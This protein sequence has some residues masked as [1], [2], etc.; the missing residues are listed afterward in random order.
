[1]SVGSRAL[2]VEP[3]DPTDVVSVAQCIAL[4]AEVFP[5]PS[6]QFGMRSAF[7]RVWVARERGERRVLGFVAGRFRR[8]VMHLEGLAVDPAARR[9]G[10][11]A[12][13]VRAAVGHA[14]TQRMRAITLDVSVSNRAALALYER[15]GFH[16]ARRLTRF[17]PAAFGGDGDAYVMV[18]PLPE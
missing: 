1:M 8:R 17:Y 9:R 13:L 16:I 7:A 3:L 10:A 2:T 14:G 18:R 4:D 6:A 15:E 5:Y 12:A 11:G